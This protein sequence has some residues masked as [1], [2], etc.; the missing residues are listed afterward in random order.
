MDQGSYKVVEATFEV[1]GGT[2]V[3]GI[4][5][6][7]NAQA[8]EGWVLV[9]TTAVREPGGAWVHVLILRRG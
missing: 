3:D 6:F 1:V 9:A 2:P 7:L 5:S 4:E 8:A